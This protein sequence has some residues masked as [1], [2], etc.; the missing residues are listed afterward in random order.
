M[1]NLIWISDMMLTAA[2]TLYCVSTILFFVSVTGQRF[3]NR[4]PKAHAKRFGR[5]GYIS[6]VLGFVAHTA[7]I[8]LRWYIGGHI[9]TSNMFEF[10][11]FLG[12]AMVVTFLGI[13]L[14]YRLP[15]IGMFVMPVA[16]LLIAYASV[17]PSEVTPL[18]PAL[19]SYWLQIHV[20]T[21]ALGEGAFAI[22]FAAGLIYLLRTVDAEKSLKSAR[23]LE[24]VMWCMVV[25]ISFVLLST[26][27]RITGYE[28]VF[29]APADIKGQIMNVEMKY[30]MPAIVGP[31]DGTLLTEG[32]MRPL[33]AAPGF[34]QGEQA[35]HKFNSVIW[36]VFG[37]T[38]LYVL[39]RLTLRKRLAHPLSR[40]VQEIDPDLADEI[41]YRAIAIGFPIFTLGALIFAMIWA[42]EAWGRF[43]GWDPKE[44]WALIT[45]LFYSVYLHL[46][47]SRGWQ[48]ERSAWMAVL[49]FIV[50]MF[51][52]VFVNLVLSGLHAYA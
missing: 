25:V 36:S 40:L 6:A 41:S 24:F 52:L 23:W 2:F 51:N 3:S 34:M 5:L 48:G 7:F 49:G 14:I 11:Q 46:R 19:Q 20:S 13:Y 21:A 15:L 28:A 31:K 18:I 35:A 45:W 42:Q 44:V 4:D 1:S 8:G 39:L 32:K 26:Y 10:T 30:S 47:L 50:V 43:W 29:R 17:F 27:F 16:V 33:F 22:G 37:G 12:Y 9:P 38:V